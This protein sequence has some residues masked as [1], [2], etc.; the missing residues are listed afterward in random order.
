MF[1]YRIIVLR[2]AL[3]FVKIYNMEQNIIQL[4]DSLEYELICQGNTAEVFLWDETTILKLFRDDFPLE[5][6]LTEFDVAFRIASDLLFAPKAFGVVEYKNRY[7]ILYE[8]IDGKDMIADM[9]HKP[10]KLRVYSKAL[11]E[12][13]AKI[14]NS[15]VDLGLD[16]K[17]KLSININAAEDLTEQE[18]GKIIAYIKTL[19]DGNALCHFDFHPGNVMIKDNEFY[20]IDW[21]TACNGNAAADAART[22]LL[23][24]YGELLY[25]NSFVKLI[26]HIVEKHIG[27]VYL[28][29]YK[30][31]TG[32][33]DAEIQKWLLPIAAARLIEWIPETEKI[34]LIK[35]IKKEL[36]EIK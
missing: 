4:D 15:T 26:A 12:T 24:N 33:T 30:K 32:V 17:S 28:R 1:F 29:Q 27:K 21:M 35:F 36:D 8:K 20:V 2:L 25:V 34:K 6:I 16:I 19:P 10:Y 3:I 22:Y 11:A 31:L 23:L 13:H 7:G 5:L 14:H 18:K 9:L